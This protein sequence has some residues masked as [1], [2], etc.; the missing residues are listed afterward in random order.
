LAPHDKTSGGSDNFCRCVQF[1]GCGSSTHCRH[2]TGTVHKDCVI[3][4]ISPF[5]PRNS[6]AAAVPL[7]KCC[8]N[9][10]QTRS[11]GNSMPSICARWSAGWL[12]C[13]PF[14]S[15]RTNRRRSPR[16]PNRPSA[17]SIRTST[18]TIGGWRAPA[19]SYAPVAT[20]AATTSHSRRRSG[21]RRKGCGNHSRCA[22][23][24]RNRD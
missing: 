21:R 16:W 19:S 12:R 9:G 1:H 10:N 22:R 4:T 18:P 24:C 15:S 13:P 3:P 17:W 11:S 2:P 20:V 23:N 8:A 14:R 5:I 6:R 7:A